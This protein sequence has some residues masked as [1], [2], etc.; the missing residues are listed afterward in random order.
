MDWQNQTHRL[1]V[2]FAILGLVAVGGVVYIYWN[3]NYHKPIEQ[4]I[5]S[6]PPSKEVL[7][8]NFDTAKEASRKIF[9]MPRNIIKR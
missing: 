8:A 1:Y 3:L 7:D 5:F 6:N 2:L 4:G 9:S